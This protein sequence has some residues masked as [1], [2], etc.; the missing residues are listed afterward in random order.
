MAGAV[1]PPGTVGRKL[2]ADISEIAPCFD[3]TGITCVTAANLMFEMLC[4]IAEGR[5]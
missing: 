4:A 1:L 3:P 5:K 2:G